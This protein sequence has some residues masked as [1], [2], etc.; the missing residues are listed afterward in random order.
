MQS[1]SDSVPARRWPLFVAGV[2][3]FLLGPA[4]Y[5]AEI[6]LGRLGTPW[7]VPILATLGVFL[8]AVSVEQRRGVVRALGLVLF[9]LLCGLEWLIVVALLK[10]PEYVGPAQPGEKIPPFSAVYADGK[11]FSNKELE[12]GGRTVLLFY[13]GHW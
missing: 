2:F 7:H 12:D 1:T 3:L 8:M 10:T 11:A 13:R 4:I 6:L 9:V 5:V